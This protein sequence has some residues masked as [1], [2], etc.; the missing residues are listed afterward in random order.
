MTVAPASMFLTAI[1][2]WRPRKARTR[3]VSAPIPLEAPEI[4]E[5]LDNEIHTTL[6]MTEED[7]II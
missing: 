1:T 4:E 2:T 5:S 7:M 6:Y 3:A